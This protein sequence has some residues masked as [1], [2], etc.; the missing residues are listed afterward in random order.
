VLFTCSL[1]LG[2][3]A[4]AQAGTSQYATAKDAFESGVRLYKVGAYEQALEAFRVA[5]K[6]KPH[7]AVKVNIANCYE[8]LKQPVQALV[9]FEAYLK[10]VENNPHLNVAPGQRQDVENEIVRLH[11]AVGH[12]DLKVSQSGSKVKVNDELPIYST[13]G[14]ILVTPGPHTVVIRKIGFLEETR[15][16]NVEAG[17]T[18]TMLVEMIPMNR[19]TLQDPSA[20]DGAASLGA[21]SDRQ[22]AL[23]SGNP[24]FRLTTPVVVAGGVTLGFATAA[25][26]TGILA[27][28]ANSDFDSALKD[29]ENSALSV[30]ERESARRRGSD[31]ANRAN[32][33]AT[34]TDVL[35]GG[36]LVG[37]GAT[38]FLLFSERGSASS[39]KAPSQTAG[40][41]LKPSFH[42]AGAG[43]VLDGRF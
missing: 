29:S 1:L 28:D 16:V 35:I 25:V 19:P 6:I 15:N 18:T 4:L 11:K 31:A 13:Q 38:V 39:E 34:V 8:H 40:L 43:F 24:R 41:G 5:Y 30:D 2:D 22:S 36:A 26:V 9:S 23:P 42:R 3:A 27:L 21:S 14:V 7:P 10:E 20:Q 17:K 37:A 33:L 12:I 32:G